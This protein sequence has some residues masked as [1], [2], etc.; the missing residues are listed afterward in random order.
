MIG[1]NLLPYLLFRNQHKQVNLHSVIELCPG[2]IECV[3]KTSA[4]FLLDNVLVTSTARS[5]ISAIEALYFC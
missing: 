5:K 2:F 1:I 3:W 4:L